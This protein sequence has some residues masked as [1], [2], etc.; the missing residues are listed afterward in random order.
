MWVLPFSVVIQSC[1]FKDLHV[2]V[3]T[4]FSGTLL[5]GVLLSGLLSSSGSCL[6]GMQ[7][8]MWQYLMLTS[9]TFNGE[10]GKTA[11]YNV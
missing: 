11:S 8:L 10:E 9:L 7:C 5:S 3:Y 4:K 1:I 6:F 2:H